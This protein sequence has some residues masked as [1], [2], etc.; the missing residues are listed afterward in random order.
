[1]STTSLEKKK[2]PAHQEVQRFSPI[3]ADV[4]RTD[5]IQLDVVL[6]HSVGDRSFCFAV[7][8]DV[9]EERHGGRAK[10]FDAGREQAD[11]WVNE[12]VRQKSLGRV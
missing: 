6:V 11:L 1:M 4:G 9:R 2:K 12:S 3:L 7:R 8:D 10:D 5:S